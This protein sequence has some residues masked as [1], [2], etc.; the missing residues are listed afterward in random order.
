MKV[1]VWDHVSGP[2]VRDIESGL[3][4]L[5]KIVGGWIEHVSIGNSV[6][7]YCNEEGKLEG[8]PLNVF[9]TA[10]VQHKLAQVGTSLLPGDV[11]VGNLIFL[12]SD[13][14]GKDTDVPQAFADEAI[15]FWNDVDDWILEG[16]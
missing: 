6:H 7:M 5:K 2:E 4:P 10:F 16:L 3:E 9:A 1:L 15:Q 14:D 8:L 11:L 12:S 13:E